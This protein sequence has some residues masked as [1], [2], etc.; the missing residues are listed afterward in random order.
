MYE[1]VASVGGS[2]GG[3]PSVPGASES[4]SDVLSQTVARLTE[5]R[6]RLSYMVTGGGQPDQAT[7][8]RGPSLVG[9]ALDVR[10]LAIEITGLVESVQTRLGVSL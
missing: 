7:A 9:Q 6:E 10:S 4:V 1:S 2:V 5:A 3:Y 8:V